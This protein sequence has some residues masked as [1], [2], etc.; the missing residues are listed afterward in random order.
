MPL[1]V[2]SVAPSFQPVATAQA[3]ARATIRIEQPVVANA[4]EWASS[5]TSSRRVVIVR[6][7][8]GQP[9]LLRLFENE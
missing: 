1:P 5:S 7:A 9:T 3:Q 2:V 6:D 8:Q 4:Q